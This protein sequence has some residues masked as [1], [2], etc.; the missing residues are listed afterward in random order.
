ME[1]A[2]PTAST[3]IS[4]AQEL[5]EKSAAFYEK[6]SERFPESKELF[7]SFADGSRKN[8]VLVTRTYQET[9]TDAIEA[10]YSFKN[11]NMDDYMIQTTLQERASHSDALKSAIQLEEVACKFY[12]EVAERCSSL[13]ATIPRAFKKVAQERGKR[14]L[15]L[16]SMLT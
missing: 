3:V 8:K 4:F 6:L 14:Q 13:L 1:T 2:N 16:E 15:K 5:E 11:L 7:L 9:I 12:S 10:C